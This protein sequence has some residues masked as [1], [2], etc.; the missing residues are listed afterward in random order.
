MRSYLEKTHQKKDWWSGSRYRPE[1]KP[2]YH[3]KKK[4]RE[5]M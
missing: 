3:K 4:K 1:F 5:M 2:Q